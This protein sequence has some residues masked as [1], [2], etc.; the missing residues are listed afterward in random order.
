MLRLHL[1]CGKRYL[2]G[3]LHIDLADFPHI[4]HRA[5]VRDLSFLPEGAAELVYASHVL[6]YFDRA[7]AID[8]LRGWRRVLKPGGVLRVAVP[9][10]ETLVGVYLRGGDLG[11]VLGPLYGRMIVQALEGE[12]TI[13]HRTAYD[14]PSLKAVLEQAGFSGVRRYD[15][16]QTLHRDHDD[17]S[18]AYLP[19]MDKEHGV[20]VSL[21]VEATRS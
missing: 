4:D 9:D 3:F 18:Q 1:G 8:V 14:F 13:Y 15:W 6:E 5:D 12:R 11:A 20:L 10:F 2:P 7:E 21:N 17:H 16:R 19:H